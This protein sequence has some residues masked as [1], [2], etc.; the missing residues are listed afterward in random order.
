[1]PFTR[2]WRPWMISILHQS[3][4]HC[5]CKSQLVCVLSLFGV[6]T[7]RMPKCTCMRI[8]LLKQCS[9][10]ST[11]SWGYQDHWS[12][13]EQAL[14]VHVECGWEAEIKSECRVLMLASKILP[15]IN[16]TCSRPV[17]EINFSLPKNPG[18]NFCE[19]DN[20]YTHAFVARCPSGLW[21]FHYF[22]LSYWIISAPKWCL[23]CTHNL[24][25]VQFPVTFAVTE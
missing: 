15:Y 12:L 22:Q 10:V 19:R 9:L 4:A 21:E 25:V 24:V 6:P 13:W 23:F 17:S 1:M 14:Q 11:L 20:R 5:W 8:T 7:F 18:A 16:T 2:W 3:L